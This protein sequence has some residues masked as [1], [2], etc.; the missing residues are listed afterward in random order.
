MASLCASFP[1]STGP[2]PGLPPDLTSP[3]SL[4]LAL[5]WAGSLPRGLLLLPLWVSTL[6]S[7]TT[8]HLVLIPLSSP[9]PRPSSC[10]LSRA[11]IIV[12][13]THSSL[14]SSSN[15]ISMQISCS[16]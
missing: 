14:S 7:S 10:L 12:F 2:W 16:G 3:P 6:P 15:A 8:L 9:P 5:D 11:L 4:L 13:C 1:C